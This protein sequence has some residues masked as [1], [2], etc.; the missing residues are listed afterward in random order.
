MFPKIIQVSFFL[1]GGGAR[2][3]YRGRGAYIWDVNW[4]TYL[5]SIYFFGGGRL[6]MGGVLIRFY[7]ISLEFSS[8]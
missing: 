2:H 7:G 4:V 3:I 1:R 6:Y 8:R 5:G